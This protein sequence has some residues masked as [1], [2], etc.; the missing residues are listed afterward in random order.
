MAVEKPVSTPFLRPLLA[1]PEIEA[2]AEEAGRAKASLPLP[3]M[4]ALAVMAGAFIAFG[5]SFMLM[6]RSDATLSFAVSMLLGGLV[7]C[8]GLFLVLVAG[9]EL[10]T[11]NCLMVAGALSGRYGWGRVVRNWAVVYAGNA[12]GAVCVALLFAAAGNLDANAGAVG[13]TALSVALAK[14][15]LAPATALVRGVLCNVLVCLAVW[16][17]FAGQSVCDKLAAAI[18]PVVGFVVLGFEHSVANLFFLPLGLIA[19]AAGVAGAGVLTPAAVAGNLLFVTVGNI[20]GGA[21]VGC[22]YWFVYG[23]DR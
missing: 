3:R 18:L 22:A 2:R 9:A 4:F 15:G 20:V 5:G 6:V 13:V 23:R 12:V 14:G 1:P 11:G 19:Q 21:L 16:M 17:G 8:L 10:F 7:F